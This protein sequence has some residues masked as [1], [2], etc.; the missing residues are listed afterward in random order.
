MENIFG[1][2]LK[3]HRLA[4]GLSVK[5]LAEKFGIKVQSVE[6]WEKG[7]TMPTGK[8]IP[9]IAQILGVTP[10]QLLE[11]EEEANELKKAAEREKALRKEI[12]ELRS[13]LI[14][15]QKKK[16]KELQDEVF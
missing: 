9:L 14:I 12:D 13:E 10:N 7:E 1:K 6:K 3:R 4:N 15:L 2:N 8:K 11:G 16:I 5:C